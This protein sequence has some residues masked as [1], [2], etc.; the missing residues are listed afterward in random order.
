MRR[1]ILPVLL[2]C[3]SAAGAASADPITVT[4]GGFTIYGAATS[5][6]GSAG[7]DFSGSGFTALGNGRLS[8]QGGFDVGVLDLSGSFNV[9]DVF[10][11]VTVGDQ[12]LR[13]FESVSLLV[14][15][16]PIVI[17]DAPQGTYGGGSAAFTATGLVRLYKPG[18]P[19]GPPLITQ[20]INGAGTLSITGQRIGNGAF[21][22]AFVG[23]G[24]APPAS[25]SPTPEPGSLLLLGTGLAAAWQSR[26]FR[27]GD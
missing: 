15:A 22:T 21:R 26:Q 7:W 17:S 10:G 19:Y 14:T 23:I 3:V 6:P 27:R 25:P 16:A 24:F 11:S 9:F 13:G 18:G 2:L 5:D 20:E 1:G 4:S 8:V 12:T